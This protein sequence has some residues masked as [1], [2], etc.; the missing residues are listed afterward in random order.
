MASNPETVL[1]VEK[2][3]FALKYA[4][5]VTVHVSEEYAVIL[6]MLERAL[7][8]ARKDDPMERARRIVA[9]ISKPVG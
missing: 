7:E 5:Y 4:A 9:S 8:D 2:I 6:E 3:E 1:T